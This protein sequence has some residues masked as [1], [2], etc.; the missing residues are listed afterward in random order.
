MFR[1]HC[2]VLILAL[3]GANAIVASEMIPA[4][5]TSGDWNSI[6]AE[7]ERNRH[8]VFSDGPGY[9]A[10]NYAQQWL[11]RFD[12]RGFLVEPE[13]AASENAPWRWGLELSSYGVSGHLH[14]VQ[15][16]ARITA[17]QQRLT[18]S[19]DANLEEW[20]VNDRGGL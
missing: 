11:T 19:W 17:D 13:R 1:L 6:R 2:L 14:P 9:H 8:Y 20:F 10:R 3:S 4:G 18:Y 16:P 7:Y 5:L 15:N 12:G